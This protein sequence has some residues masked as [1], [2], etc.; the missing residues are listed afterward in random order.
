MAMRDYDARVALV[1][2]ERWGGSCPNVACSPTKAYLVAAELAHDVNELAPRMGVEAG[3]ARIDLAGVRAWKETLKR[4]QDEWVAMLMEQGYATYT[5]EASFLDP[6]RVRV[7]ELVLEAERILVASG[8]RTAIPPIDGIDE[9]GWIDH[10]SALELTEL[11]ASVLVVGA[12]AV[13]LE[14]GQI[15][16]RFGSKVTIVD[17]AERIAPLAD[18]EVS[19]MLGAALRYEGIVIAASV[20]V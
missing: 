12:G 2:R 20:F 3:P 15:F 11:P 16:S 8:S 17:A 10:V 7:G 18:A 13:G 5:G 19:A 4:T 9:V 6:H 1:E 14:F